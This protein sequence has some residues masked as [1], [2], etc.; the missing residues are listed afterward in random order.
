MHDS[1]TINNPHYLILKINLL[2]SKIIGKGVAWFG[3]S[4]ATATV[5][6]HGIVWWMQFFL[7][8]VVQYQLQDYRIIELHGAQW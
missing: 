5:I 8:Q 7:F 6:Q 1:K 4:S 2:G 3:Q